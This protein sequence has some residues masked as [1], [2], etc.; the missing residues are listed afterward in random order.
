[1]GSCGM[2][3]A[4]ATM[5]KIATTQAKMG[6]SMK[7]LGIVPS[8]LLLGGGLC[9]VRLCGLSRSRLT[10]RLAVRVPFGR[11]DHRSGADLLEALDNHL[12]ASLQAFRHH[13]AIADGA[14]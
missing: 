9:A 12:F 14:P 4:P 7:K 6:L 5:M 1:M 13:P 10:G 2:A 8:S 11:N 3:M